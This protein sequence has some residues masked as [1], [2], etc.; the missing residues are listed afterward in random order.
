MKA[1]TLTKISD[2]PN[3]L[4]SDSIT[5]YCFGEPEVGR[6]F[7]V[8][9]GEPLSGDPQFN[10]RAVTTSVVQSVESVGPGK[11]QITTMNSIYE[12]TIEDE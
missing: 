7:S 1:A 8:I 11:F 4:R 3:A 12:V 10:A 2:N 9:N 6:S 5:G